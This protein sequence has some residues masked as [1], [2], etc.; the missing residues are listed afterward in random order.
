MRFAI[1]SDLHGNL[2]AW[3]AIQHDMISQQVETIVCLGDVV[4]YGP[5][6]EEVLQAVRSVTA[7]FVLGNHDAAA[8]GRMDASIFNDNA[9]AIVEWTGSVLSQDS[10]HFLQQVPLAMDDGQ[11]TYF[12]HAEIEDPGRFGYIT[13]VDEARTNFAATDASLTFIGHTHEPAVFS[14]DG[15]GLV[16][17]EPVM[18]FQL[19]PGHRYLVN[20]GSAGE[21]R[22]YD[23][24]A[25]YCLFDD[26]TKSIQFRRVKFDVEAYRRDIQ[27]VGL[28]IQPFFLYAYDEMQ[29]G[30]KPVRAPEPTRK[31]EAIIRPKSIV[32]EAPP[33]Q[34][35]IRLTRTTTLSPG[36]A[37]PIALP[38]S[39]FTTP[40]GKPTNAEK[41]IATRPLKPR[42]R[43][44][45]TAT[46][47]LLLVALA[48]A[49]AFAWRHFQ[50]EE[51][52]LIMEES[53]LLGR[54]SSPDLS[55]SAA[56]T[57][58]ITPIPAGPAPPLPPAGVVF[59][60]HLDEADEA[61]VLRSASSD[62]V[63]RVQAGTYRTTEGKFGNAM[64]SVAIPMGTRWEGVGN[65]SDSDSF[66][67]SV[68]VK[69]ANRTDGS[70]LGRTAWNGK[71]GYQ[72]AVIKRDNQR[73]LEFQLIGDPS[74]EDSIAYRVHEALPN[75]KWT[76][77]AVTHSMKSGKRLV[78]LFIHGSEAPMDRSGAN[79]L[80]GSIAV[81]APFRIG[82]VGGRTRFK[83]F[84]D[85]VILF[86]R[87]LS[88][89]E[90]AA[91]ANPGN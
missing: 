17:S 84:I 57:L 19:Q 64:M 89:E 83:G 56:N 62:L 24:R 52:S 30:A 28:N 69:G 66:T 41:I 23:V 65:F 11:S 12:V 68:W 26:T 81:N 35:P 7:N 90:I 21:P 14:M 2:P 43:K 39:Q 42:R 29:S 67:A 31:D 51:E 34:K 82:S 25:S 5:R 27:E 55:A 45:K 71:G 85:E 38:S 54:V 18:D 22:D 86:D 20:V 16:T 48:G 32:T 8:C 13:N 9:R 63:G 79:K 78:K 75:R 49:G 6:P 60:A 37:R 74:Q 88:D 40:A 61:T 77:I 33:N 59:H 10:H 87:V 44:R 76:H 15:S 91:L 1:F 46:L 36:Q 58:P 70:I 50:P 47:L 80:L 72:L 3:Q 53:A 73:R 4:G